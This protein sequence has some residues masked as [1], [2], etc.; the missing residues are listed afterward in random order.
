MIG[1]EAG[2][3][4]TGFRFSGAQSGM[5]HPPGRL[6]RRSPRTVISV[7]RARAFTA[8]IHEAQRS[9]GLWLAQHPFVQAVRSGSAKRGELAWWAHQ[10]YCV[11]RTYGAILRSMN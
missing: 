2:C 3:R 1:R 4:S 5:K 6:V 11:T 9:E 8:A 10:T 7:K